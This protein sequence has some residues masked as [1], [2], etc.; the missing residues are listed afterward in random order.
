MN[1]KSKIG[2]ALVYEACPVCGKK[3][4]EHIIINRVL[5]E[6]YAQKIED[7]HNKC[8]GYAEKPC[9][10]CKDIMKEDFLCII[11]DESKTKDESNPYRTGQIIRIKKDCNFVKNIDPELTKKGLCFVDIDFAKKIGLIQE[12]S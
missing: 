2:T 8:V 12:E 5:T 10:E 6:K 9:D 3:C 11:Y 1:K 7:L 4:N